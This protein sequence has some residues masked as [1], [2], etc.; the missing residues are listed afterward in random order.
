MLGQTGHV[1]ELL[2]RFGMKDSHPVVARISNVNAGE[3]L[4]AKGHEL[5]RTVM[6]SLLY[7]ACWSRSNIALAIQKCRGLCR[8][9]VTCI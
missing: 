5:C 2:D 3:K 8:L 7:L 1:G 4:H 6:G 9:R